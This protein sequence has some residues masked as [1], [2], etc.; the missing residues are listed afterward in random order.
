MDHPSP[1]TYDRLYKL[2]TPSP[3]M[4]LFTEVVDENDIL[5]LL[6][7]YIGSGKIVDAPYH[8]PGVDNENV[9]SL[10]NR[11][12]KAVPYEENVYNHHRFIDGRVV[13]KSNTRVIYGG[14]GQWRPQ[15]WTCP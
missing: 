10:R 2:L 9:T 15:C 11:T 8:F 6:F 5:R 13:S 14:G 1:I 4:G 3:S 7:V 12:L